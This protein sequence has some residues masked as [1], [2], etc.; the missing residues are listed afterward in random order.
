MPFRNVTR[1]SWLLGSVLAMASCAGTSV[2]L[3]AEADVIGKPLPN[4]AQP[5]SAPVEVSIPAPPQWQN[6]VHGFPGKKTAE[7]LSKISPFD[8]PVTTRGATETSVFKKAAPS[9]V[10]VFRKTVLGPAHI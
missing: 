9:V 6:L 7:L 10:L 3:S 4:G 2:G 5:S 8:D 1:K